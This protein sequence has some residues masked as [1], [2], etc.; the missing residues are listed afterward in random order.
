MQNK[1]AAPSE[2]L[3]S[4]SHLGFELSSEFLE[5]FRQGLSGLAAKINRG[6]RKVRRADSANTARSAFWF[7]P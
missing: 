4:I 2:R 7:C 6:A 1:K 5:R 3:A